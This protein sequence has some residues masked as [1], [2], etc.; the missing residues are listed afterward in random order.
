ML[1]V[2]LIMDTF[3]AMALASIP[4][5]ADVM[6]EKQ[7]KTDDF[8]ITK[9]MRK[10]ILCVGLSLIHI[11]SDSTLNTMRIRSLTY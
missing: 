11:L 5:S 4:P 7:R 10:N 2:N 9:A 1:W 6:N 8:I 3:A